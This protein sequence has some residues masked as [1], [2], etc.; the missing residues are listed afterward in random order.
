MI[1][2]IY[3]KHDIIMMHKKKLFIMV[4]NYFQK[5]KIPT[6]AEKKYSVLSK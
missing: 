3:H 6:W 1:Y 5:V 4:T 2:D